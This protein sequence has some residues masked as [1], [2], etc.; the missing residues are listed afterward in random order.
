MADPASQAV[1]VVPHTPPPVPVTPPPPPAPS[2]S[3]GHS[4]PHAE[5]AS[6]GRRQSSSPQRVPVWDGLRRMQGHARKTTGLPPRHQIAQ[7]DV[8]PVIHEVGESSHQAELRA[9]LQQ[10]SQD[11]QG[12][13]QDIQQQHATLEDT[14]TMILSLGGLPWRIAYEGHVVKRSLLHFGSR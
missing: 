8:P 6:A 7:R 14:R 13:R 12:A 9:Q 2:G 5:N 11:L 1:P 4:Q 3:Q 10:V